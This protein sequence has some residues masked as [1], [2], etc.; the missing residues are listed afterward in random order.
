MLWTSGGE[1]LSDV[2][3]HV[4]RYIT[5]IATKR[6]WRCIGSFLKRLAYRF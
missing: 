3:L 2:T 1:L 5:G 6:D 4:L